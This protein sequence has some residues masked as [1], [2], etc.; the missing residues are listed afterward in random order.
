MGPTQPQ[1]LVGR[2][3]KGAVGSH[4]PPGVCGVAPGVQCTLSPTS[5][6][7]LLLQNFS[8][9]ARAMRVNSNSCEKRVIGI[10]RADGVC[11][12]NLCTDRS[13]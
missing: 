12:R 2:A 3:E 11:A 13:P 4:G 8:F 6:Q 9:S 1:V 5:V 7:S 10:R